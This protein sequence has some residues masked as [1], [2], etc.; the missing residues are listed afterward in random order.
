M[1]RLFILAVA[2][3]GAA[4]SDATLPSA[5]QKAAPANKASLDLICASGYVVAF[6]EN[7]DPYCAEAA[8]RPAQSGRTRS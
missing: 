3:I 2:L 6:D 5:P 4:C 1:K 7:G 8:S